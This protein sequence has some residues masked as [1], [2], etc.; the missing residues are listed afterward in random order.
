MDQGRTKKEEGKRR[1]LMETT[2]LNRNRKKGQGF[3]LQALR[4]K[5]DEGQPAGCMSSAWTKVPLF[6]AGRWSPISVLHP[7]SFASIFHLHASL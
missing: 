7:P 6:L 2:T 4:T 5:T 1:G 3:L